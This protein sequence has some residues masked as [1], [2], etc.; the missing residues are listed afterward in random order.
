MVA[1]IMRKNSTGSLSM[2]T[3]SVVIFIKLSQISFTKFSGLP[4]FVL[5]G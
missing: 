1:Q 4:V 3:L 2:K 5:S